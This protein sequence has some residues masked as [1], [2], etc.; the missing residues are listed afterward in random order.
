MQSLPAVRSTFPMRYLGLPLSVKQL[1]RIH[2]QYL[3]DQVARRLPPWQGRHCTAAG[4]TELV[5]SVL[6]AI[7][8]YHI[9]SL[10][11][12]AE[13]L[14][15]IDKI[16]RAFLWAGS[17]KVSGVKCKINWT[18]VCRPL[19]LGGL[20]IL[21]LQKFGRA[22]RLR[23]P[24]LEWEAPERTWVGTGNPCDDELGLVSRPHKGY[25]W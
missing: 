21:P 7:M 25:H 5:R 12:P 9:T 18:S 13:V 17:D 2:F 10:T 16:R 22:L 23:W 24:W 11:I 4:R 3:E 8:I 15:A 20:G 1:K 14:Q 19:S 6:T